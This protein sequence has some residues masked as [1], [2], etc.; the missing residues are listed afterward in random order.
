[1]MRQGLER[2]RAAGVGVHR[3]RRETRRP[4]ASRAR[5]CS[6]ST[7]ARVRPPWP[8]RGPGTRGRRQT[9]VP[10]LSPRLAR[11]RAQ[12][13]GRLLD[14]QAAAVA[15]LAV[16]GDRAAMGQAVQRADG[17]LHHPVAGAIVETRDQA[18]PAR[19][20]LIGGSAQTPIAGARIARRCRLVSNSALSRFVMI[21]AHASSQ[22][23]RCTAEPLKTTT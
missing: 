18:E 21:C 23:L 4:R 22:A 17:R 15:G 13:S 5:S 19:V 7:R 1:M 9:A 2:L 8:G 14:Q 16:G 3:Q 12:E 10:S 20:L 6:V 11:H